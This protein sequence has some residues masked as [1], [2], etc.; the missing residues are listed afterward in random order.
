MKKGAA[1][2]AIGIVILIC[3]LVGVNVWQSRSSNPSSDDDQQT[4]QQQPSQQSP[5][6][7]ASTDPADHPVA[8]LTGD[9]VSSLV[10]EQTIGNPASATTRITIGYTFDTP[11]QVNPSKAA[12]IVDAVR[13]W[14][15]KQ[16][17]AA[18]L[19]IVCV[20]L[21]VNQLTNPADSSVPLGI[22]ID[23]RQ[24]P[25]LGQNPGEG[26]YTAQTVLKDLG[27]S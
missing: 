19:Q 18:S 7:S 14:V 5:Q 24:P 21:P 12:A 23:G 3:L 11:T 25:G 16:G 22:T 17:S 13:D 8:N 4:S 9:L 20:D 1:P 27:G 10:P 2:I 15:Q 26:S 6:Q